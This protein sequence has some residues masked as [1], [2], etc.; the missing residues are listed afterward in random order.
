MFAWYFFILLLS[1]F[2][3]F[4]FLEY[5]F[6]KQHKFGFYFFNSSNAVS[7][8][9]VHSTFK[10]AYYLKYLGL[11]YLLFVPSVLCPPPF[12]SFSWNKQVF[13]LFY[14]LPVIF[15]GMHFNLFLVF[16]LHIIIYFLGLSKIS[17]R[18]VQTLFFFFNF[19]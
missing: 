9:Q 2:S 4:I 11:T 1:I 17:A 19:F 18:I 5:V 3:T 10:F 16:I 12:L 13:L 7:L 6:C 15:L 14:F 8:I